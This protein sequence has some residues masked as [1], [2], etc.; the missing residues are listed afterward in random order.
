MEN[1]QANQAENNPAPEANPA[2]K[3]QV[4]NPASLARVSSPEQLNDYIRVANPSVWLILTA[5]IVLLAALLV[6]SMTG[7]LPTTISE[8]CV[9]EGGVLT[10][11]LSDKADVAPGMRVRIGSLTGTITAISDTPYSSR[12]VGAKY[13]DD[14][15]LHMLG[16][17]DWNYEIT[18]EA[19]GVPDG[20]VETTIVTGEVQPI[21]FIFN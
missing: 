21:T 3:A 6:W 13:D 16:V 20:L 12:E 8:T 15:M 18:I 5:M 4:F 1:K 19:P 11:Y 2:Q 14:Y 9:A 17:D 7:T 10:G